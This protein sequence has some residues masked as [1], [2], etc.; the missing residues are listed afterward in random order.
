MA[1]ERVEV[2][3][4]DAR[5]YN[6]TFFEKITSRGANLLPNTHHHILGEL[7][8]L[9]LIHKHTVLSYPSINL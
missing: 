5:K 9:H 8:A 7:A 6:M 4:G 3:S 2:L 1:V